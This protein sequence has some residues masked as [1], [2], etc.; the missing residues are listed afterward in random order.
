MSLAEKL[1]HWLRHIFMNIIWEQQDCHLHAPD[2][3]WATTIGASYHHHRPSASLSLFDP[4]GLNLGH[5]GVVEAR[6]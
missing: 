2:G 3:N 4:K 1:G 6:S 5:L